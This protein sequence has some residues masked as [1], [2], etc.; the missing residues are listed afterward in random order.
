MATS[1]KGSLLGVITAATRKIST[2]AGRRHRLQ[3]RL[4]TTPTSSRNTTTNGYMKTAPNTK[5]MA[6]Y[7]VRYRDGE[8]SGATPLPDTLMSQVNA[9]GK[10]S[11]AVSHPGCKQQ[12][13][14]ADKRDC[15]ALLVLV[16]SGGDETPQLPE[17]HRRGHGH[18]GVDA[19]LEAGGEALQGSGDHQ[20]TLGDVLVPMYGK[21]R[22]VR[23]QHE[24]ENL[25]VAE[26]ADQGR[27]TDRDHTDDHTLTQLSQVLEQ[28]HL[29]QFAVVG[30]GGRPLT[31]VSERHG[32]DCSVDRRIVG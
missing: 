3:V 32:V 15:V 24:A 19:D 16:Q 31:F 25:V 9:F 18:P 26:P 28:G 7:I 23:M 20:L 17:D 11:T 5:H 30:L 2:M 21:V 22:M 12:H 29:P 10:T 13:R 27:H 14:P 8:N 4:G 1:E 6:T